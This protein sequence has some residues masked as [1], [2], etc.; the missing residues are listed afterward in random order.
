LFHDKTFDGFDFTL[1]MVE[2][3]GGVNV[4]WYDLGISPV[5]LL[6]PNR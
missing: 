5:E 4:I 3:G 1:K 2:E 6:T